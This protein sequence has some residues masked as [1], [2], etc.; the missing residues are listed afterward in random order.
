L[1]SRVIEGH[2]KPLSDNQ[3][4]T[5]SDAIIRQPERALMSESYKVH[6]ASKRLIGAREAPRKSQ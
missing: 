4:R 5:I 1:N 3:R 2:A 6:Q